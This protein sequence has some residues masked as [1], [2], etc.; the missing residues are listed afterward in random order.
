MVITSPLKIK[1][2][3]IVAPVMYFG[4]LGTNSFILP[5]LQLKFYQ[6]VARKGSFPLHHYVNPV[7]ESI[8]VL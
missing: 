1:G 2:G 5:S 8:K 3:Y 4:M 7:A 6:L